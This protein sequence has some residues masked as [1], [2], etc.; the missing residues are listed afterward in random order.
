M[1][2]PYPT[3]WYG[4]NYKGVSRQFGSSLTLF[5]KKMPIWPY[6]TLIRTSH[7]NSLIITH[8]RA[9]NSTDEKCQKS[10]QTIKRQNNEKKQT[11]NFR[12]ELI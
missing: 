10:K 3:V 12:Q 2:G 5:L 9:V 4:L 6:M 8:T 11:K 7:G 1:V